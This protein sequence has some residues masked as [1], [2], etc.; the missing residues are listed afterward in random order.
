MSEVQGPGMFST[1]K[2]CGWEKQRL[3]WAFGLD[4]FRRIG[5]SG[6]GETNWVSSTFGFTA[7]SPEGFLLEVGEVFEHPL[8]SRGA[9]AGLN[10]GKEPAAIQ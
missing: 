7:Y 4:T 9:L 5:L 1:K 8:G 2:G 6:Y 3:L 10:E